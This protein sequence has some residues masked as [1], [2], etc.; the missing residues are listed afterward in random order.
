[1]PGSDDR[2]GAEAAEQEQFADI[3][4]GDRG[5]E[6]ELLHPVEQALISKDRWIQC[7][8]GRELHLQVKVQ[9]AQFV[10]ANVPALGEVDAWQL[11]I[12]ITGN[13]NETVE[14]V[15][16]VYANGRWRFALD[17]P[18]IDHISHGECP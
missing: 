17:Q 16:R 13:I 15:Y 4:R 14:T 6:W 10:R 1:M 12:D 3:S 5:A 2:A 18:G 8:G 9:D 11:K 7:N